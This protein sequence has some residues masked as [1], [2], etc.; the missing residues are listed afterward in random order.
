MVNF[1]ARY[2]ALVGL[3][4]L[5]AGMAHGQRPAP[6]RPEPARPAI[7]LRYL[8]PERMPRLP[9]GASDAAS[10]EAALRAHLRYRPP[11]G[12][13]PFAATDIAQLSFTI[14]P[15]GRVRDARVLSKL[16]PGF[17]RAVLAAAAQLPRFAPGRQEGQAVAVR[18]TLAVGAAGPYA[19]NPRT[20]PGPVTLPPDWPE[21]FK[22]P[23]AAPRLPGNVSVQT[24]LLQRVVYPQAAAD[25][26]GQ[27]PY[28]K[29]AFTVD[30]LGHPTDVL[31]EHSG[32]LPYDRA[33]VAAL[34]ALPPFEPYRHLRRKV[35]VRLQVNLDFKP[36]PA[37]YQP[38]VSNA[39]P[40]DPPANSPGIVDALSAEQRPAAERG[41]LMFIQALVQHYTVVPEEVRQGKV[42]GLVL[43][44]AV[45]GLSG[46]VYGLRIRQSLSAACDS[47]ALAAVRRLPLLT[48][49]QYRG[50]TVAMRLTLPVR[51]WGPGHVYEPYSASHPATF[52]TDLEAYVRANLRV[53]D[54]LRKAPLARSVDVL[55]LIAADGRVQN[56][57]LTRPAQLAFIDEEALRFAHA[58]PPWQPARDAQNQPVASRVPLT[59]RFPPLS[60]AGAGPPLVPKPAPP[61]PGVTK[62]VVEEIKPNPVYTY[63][64][65][66]PEL[67]GGGG[68]AAIKAALQARFRYPA[69]AGGA[70]VQGVITVRFL[71][72]LDG[73]VGEASIVKGLSAAADRAALAAV[74][75]LPHF[76]PGKQSGQEVVVAY[77][78]PIAVAPPAKP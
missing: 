29:L 60:A 38:P 27:V 33:A 17:G 20:E 52:A 39:L 54:S 24:A 5:L 35:A 66:M 47:A 51:F 59:L 40:A 67:P 28:V 50:Q 46:R 49:G 34:A 6:A 25:R 78:V 53:S 58:M 15:D 23:M 36:R 68:L 73:R 61:T 45:A 76:T 10:I 69:G 77:T 42:D 22:Y 31:L 8:R 56:A 64:E 44:D 43:V 57:T 11:A 7:E 21:V 37:G 30:T 1:Y 18:Y 3:V 74:Q 48:P 14:G 26:Y 19:D 72:G 75:A 2:P 63:V 32:G 62:K 9:G 12:R 16:E 41:G 70:L 65:Q 4:L 71:V 55:V 13:P